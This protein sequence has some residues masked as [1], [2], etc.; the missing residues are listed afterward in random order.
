MPK[1]EETPALPLRPGRGLRIALAVSLALNLAVAGVV[2]G[3]VV[4]GPPGPPAMLRDLGFGPFAAALTE[5]DRYALRAAFL[6]RKPDLRSARRAMHE[7]LAA[8]SA[9][10]RADPFRPEDLRA[11]MNRGAA[12]TEELL[13]VGRM[14]LIDHVVSLPPE[15]RRAMADRMDAALERQGS[16][17]RNGE[18][19][20]KE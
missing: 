16:A 5:S 10:L 12:R 19:A 2:V 6:A 1:D 3:L 4:N 7:D 18:G 14:L 20:R 17:R 9:A 13:S 15:A 11:A 8:V